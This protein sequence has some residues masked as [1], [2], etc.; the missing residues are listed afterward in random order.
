[1]TSCWHPNKFIRSPSHPVF[2]QPTFLMR[3]HYFWSC[4][5]TSTQ[6]IP[7]LTHPSKRRLE[8]PMWTRL[9][10][11]YHYPC[12]LSSRNGEILGASMN[13]TR[14]QTLV[15]S[16]SAR[17]L[18]FSCRSLVSQR[19]MGMSDSCSITRR[20]L[21]N[22]SLEFIH[23]R[24]SS[25][26]AMTYIFCRLF[27]SGKFIPMCGV[28]RTR[29][30]YSGLCYQMYASYFVCVSLSKTDNLSTRSS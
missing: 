27:G 9:R 21:L 14:M 24:H 3:H 10:E 4:R 29:V 25:V 30:L 17:T 23:V 28:R 1:M 5:R 12:S 20:M 7:S 16:M 11:L 19:R 18:I 26:P 6:R 2:C 8:L 22:Y 13:V 15:Y